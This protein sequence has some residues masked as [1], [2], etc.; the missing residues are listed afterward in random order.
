VA[1]LSLAF[2]LTGCRP[3]SAISR[4]P[5]SIESLCL[6]GAP[7]ARLFRLPGL[8]A[9]HNDRLAK[10]QDP[11]VDLEAAERVAVAATHELGG[12]PLDEDSARLMVTEAGGGILA[13]WRDRPVVLLFASAD[14]KAKPEPQDVYAIAI[15][16]A[17]RDESRVLYILS[18]PSGSSTPP[19]WRAVD[20][21]DEEHVCM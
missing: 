16:E 11:H 8:D 14:P 2:S 13:W 18:R 3:K 9:Q 21:A 19:R 6:S 7:I 10:G 15:P 17:L 12:P 5:T 1:V 20:S 4:P